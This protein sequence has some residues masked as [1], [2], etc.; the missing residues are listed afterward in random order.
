MTDASTPEAPYFDPLELRVALTGHY[1]AAD[2]DV[3]QARVAVL[4]SLKAVLKDAHDKA[5]ANLELDGN[6]RACAQRLSLFQDELIRVIYDYTTTHVYRTDNPDD[7][8]HMAVI[9]TGGYGRGL[10]APGSDI[11]LLFLLPYKQTAWGESVVEY[12]L[13]IMWDLG[14]KVGHATRS[15]DQTIKLSLADMTIRTAV[16]DARLIL[17]DKRLFDELEQRFA[18]E[19]VRGTAAAFFEAKLAEREDRHKR[20]GS[21]RYLVEPNIKDGKGGLRD[22]HTLHWLAKYQAGGTGPDNPFASSVFTPAEQTTFRRCEDF[23]WTVR[24]HLHFLAGRPEERLSFDRQPVLAERL[25]YKDRGGLRSVE[26]F[27]KHYF[28]MAKDVGDLTAILCSALEMQQ[29]VRAPSMDSLFN[30]FGWRTRRRIRQTTDFRIDNGRLNVA[31]AE[32]FARDPVNL[33]RFFA[34]SEE[35][36]VLIH[37]AALRLI[38]QSLRL[39]DDKLRSDPEANRIFLSLLTAPGK[40]AATLRRMNEAG[41][42]GRFVP[43]FGA[44]VSMMQFN[45]YHHYTV[46]EHLIRTVGVISEI[47]RGESEK[48]HPLSHRLIGSVENKRVLF[49]AAFLHDIAKGRQE[50][51]SIAGA[52]VARL[53]CPRFGLTPAETDLVV[54]LVL[55]HLDMSTIAQSRDLSD[56]KTIRHFA[57]LVETPERLKLLLI[58]TVSDIRAVGPTTWNGWKGQLLR[59]L[60]NEV[61]PVVEGRHSETGFSERVKAAKEAFRRA[62]GQADGAVVERFVA[63]HYDDY[64]TKTDTKHQLQHLRLSEAARTDGRAYATHYATDAFTAVTE[65]TILAPN[66]ARLL[67][68]FAGACA[69]A[70]ANIVGAHITTTRDG[71]A[72]DTFLLKREFE[73]DDD[74]QRRAGRIGETIERLLRGQTW[75]EQL[76]ARRRVT[77]GTIDAFSVEP[78]VTIDNDVSDQFTVVEV[79]GL[80]RPGLLYEVTSA[81]SD[82]NL[83]IT[84]AHITTFGERAVDAFYVTDLTNKK[85]VA[86]ARQSAIRAHLVRVLNGEEAVTPA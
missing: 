47:V 3:G 4:D 64:W 73:R 79:V 16:L 48:A 68:M 38:R 49:V 42:L 63:R 71:F 86:P 6:G 57:D 60:Y 58:L 85:I 17:G 62:A 75:L 82:L 2:G 55:H 59:T 44:V 7:A 25:G 78:A 15:V 69:A 70:G 26:R 46:D 32:V 19:V 34:N 72:L 28:L 18:T 54:W 40:P 27:M 10:M 76:M 9:A 77:K 5:R 39:I 83:D 45:M 84:S 50:D 11:D 33:I 81:L 22:L 53:L 37:P 74:E 36:Q 35:A 51:H 29:L 1:R 66:H 65:L 24:C 30:P 43:E 23:L 67:A 80:D 8:E 56:P 12:M 61:L 21:S 13:M 31:D 41:V 20:S 52:R 14:Q